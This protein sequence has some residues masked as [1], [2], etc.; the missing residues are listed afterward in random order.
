MTFVSRAYTGISSD[1]EI[2][3]KSVIFGYT[4]KV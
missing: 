2:T 3:R 1:K 4:A